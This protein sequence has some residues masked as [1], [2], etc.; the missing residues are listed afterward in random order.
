MT[1]FA[2]THIATNT[3]NRKYLS[4]N[5]TDGYVFVDKLDKALLFDTYNYAEAYLLDHINSISL[6]S[7]I[8]S[9]SYNIVSIEVSLNPKK[10]CSLIKYHNQSNIYFD[11]S[12]LYDEN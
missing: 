5:T 10:V 7:N 11:R 2:I 1:K 3:G 12:G 6:T 9:V 8:F 4:Y